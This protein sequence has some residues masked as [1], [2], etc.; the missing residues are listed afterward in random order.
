[1][2]RVTG[3]RSITSGS[4]PDYK[5]LGWEDLITAYNIISPTALQAGQPEDVSVVLA[6]LQAI[7]S[8]L[9]GQIDNANISPAASLAISKLAG[10]PSDGAKSLLGD[11]TW[12]SVQGIPTGVIL[13][14]GGA[15]SPTGWLFCDGAAVSRTVYSVLFG[16]VGS[17]YGPGDGTTTFNLPDLQGRAPVG[18]GT[19]TD[20]DTLGKS[21]GIAAAS[22]SNKHR[23]TV[24]DPGHSHS[25]AWGS[26][27]GS[28]GDVNGR[29]AEGYYGGITASA[30]GITVG[31][32]GTPLDTTP[33][34]VTN[35][36]IKT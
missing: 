26:I 7:A 8:V 31:P 20:V 29:N 34:L 23:H 14:Y 19:H 3:Y 22:R 24:N 4:T 32:A 18:K 36:V 15:A 30:T 10:Y 12:G 5:Q 6:N 33:Y 17:S 16:I 2:Q 21:D 13:P 25:R 27:G 9:N 35:Y 11:G 1:M 28:E